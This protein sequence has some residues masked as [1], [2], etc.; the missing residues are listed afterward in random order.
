M[1][2]LAWRQH[3]KQG[4]FAVVGLAVLAA[5]LV[6]TGI[7]MHH[8]FTD[9][10]LAECL[11]KL[12]TAEFLKPG[13]DCDS[14]SSVFT[15]QYGTMATLGMLSVFL[16][17]LVGLF[18]GAPL[19]A[20][21]LEQGTHRL[22][23]TQGVSRLRWALVKFG[24]VLAG[25]LIVSVCYALLLSW[26]LEPLSQAGQGRLAE[27]N[28]DVQ[29]VA[30]VAYT[31]YAV[32]LGIFAGTVWRRVLPA[33][34]A[35]L[36]G[37]LALRFVLLLGVRA[38][39]LPISERTYPVIGQIRPNSTLGDWIYSV[40]I[41]DASGKVVA[42]NQQIQCAPAVAGNPNGPCAAFGP[43]AYNFQLYQPGGNFW[44]IQFIE[45]GLFT[46]LAAVLLYLAIRQI[47]TRIA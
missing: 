35:A 16:P 1:I 19:V 31:L 7:S 3:R 32:A 46:A 43:G 21:E 25:T 9:S 15:N 36:I 13:A 10:G 40:G 23:W 38:H 17:L 27:L 28:F 12:G 11:R 18:W 6:P 24:L 39:F 8:T 42:A 20:R 5:L 2:W 45:A 34:A 47:R 14:L 22:V 30:P 44:P 26:W 33:M 41:K 4:L 29:G 37:F